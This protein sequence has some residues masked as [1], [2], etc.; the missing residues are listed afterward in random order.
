MRACSHG[1][2]TLKLAVFACRAADGVFLRVLTAPL[3]C[4]RHTDISNFHIAS[5][6]ATTASQLIPY[7]RLHTTQRLT[8]THLSIVSTH[9]PDDMTR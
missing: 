3:S 4:P 2:L 1:R 8:V 7:I 6:R 9:H 5:P